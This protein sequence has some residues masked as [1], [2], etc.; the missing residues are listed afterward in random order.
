ME[1]YC[2]DEFSNTIYSFKIIDGTKVVES[3]TV[4]HADELAINHS[5]AR[6]RKDKK[7]YAEQYA[8]AASAYNSHH[9]FRMFR[10]DL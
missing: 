10:P 2:S 9:N 1:L 6:N 8:S 5:S 7:E 3:D 4:Y